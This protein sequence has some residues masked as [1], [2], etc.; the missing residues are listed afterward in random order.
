[1]SNASDS[2]KNILSKIEANL[3]FKRNKED[4]EKTFTDFGNDKFS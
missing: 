1:M 3:N 4:P 2:I